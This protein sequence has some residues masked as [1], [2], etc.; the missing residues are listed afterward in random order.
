MFQR[1]LARGAPRAGS[2]MSAATRPQIS[3]VRRAAVPA[4]AQVDS[5]R[6]YHEKDKSPLA[7][8]ELSQAVVMK[9]ATATVIGTA[10]FSPFQAL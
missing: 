5:R 7:L 1:A 2:I 10:A 6:H 3:G 4:V 9:Q 8:N